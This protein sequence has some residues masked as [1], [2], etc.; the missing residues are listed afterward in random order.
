MILDERDNKASV[1]ILV[2]G[3]KRRQRANISQCTCPFTVL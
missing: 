1:Y 3:F 2:M